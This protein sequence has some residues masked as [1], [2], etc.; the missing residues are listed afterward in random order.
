MVVVDTCILIDV[1]DDDPEFGEVSADCLAARLNDGLT[2]SPVS[3]V[4]LA[5]VFN[6]SRR[7]LDEF[8][9]GLGVDTIAVFDVARIARPPFPRGR[10]TSAPGV[11]AEAKAARRRCAH[12]RARHAARW[13]DHPECR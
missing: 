8:L 4:E 11:P 10:V 13:C 6:G 1:A 9:A 2:V 5:P 3:Y 12:W 7:L